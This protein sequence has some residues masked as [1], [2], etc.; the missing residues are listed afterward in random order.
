MEETLRGGFASGDANM[1]L[2]AHEPPDEHR[3]ATM[4]RKLKVLFQGSL[5][6]VVMFTCWSLVA[7][8][9]SAPKTGEWRYYNGDAAST[10]YSAL[11]QIDKTNV[12]DLSIVWRWKTENFGPR[13]AFAYEVTPLMIGGKLYVTAGTRRDV[14]AIDAVTGE[15]LWMWRY[16]EGKRG[17]EAPRSAH[18]GVAYWTDGTNDERIFYITAGYQ[19]VGLDAKTGRELKGFGKNGVVDLFDDLDSTMSKEGLIG[20]TSPPIV[21][22]NIVIVGGALESGLAPRSKEGVPGNIR[23]YD[24]RTGKRVWI[25]HT[26]PQPGEYGVDTWEK[27]SWRYTGG[28]SAWAP[29]TA[30]EELGYVYLPIGPRTG[31]YYGGH[32]PGSN[33]YD[34]SL[35]CLDAK[36]GKR[37]WHYQLVHHGLWDYDIAA[38]PIL[39]DITVNG[40]KIKAVA[41]LTKGPAYVF[42]FDR[43]TGKPVWPIEE[44]PVPQ[45]DVPGEKTWPTQPIPTKPAAYDRNGVS[46][47]DLIDFT[48]E[49]KAEAVKIVSDYKIGPLYTPPSL[50]SATGLRGTLG[51]PSTGSGAANWQGGAL[52]PE[53]GI[54]YIP[55]ASATSPLSLWHDP[56]TQHTNMDYIGLMGNVPPPPGVNPVDAVRQATQR[57]DQRGAEPAPAPAATTGANRPF[58]GPQGLPILKPPYG[59]ITAIDLNTGEQVWMVPNGETPD[60]IKNHPALRGLNIPKTGR[61]ERDGVLVTKTLLFAGDS[62]GTFRAYDK[63]TGEIVSEMKL[64]SGQTGVPM[65]YMV[66]GKQY[67]AVAIGGRASYAEIVVLALR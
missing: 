53:T 62:T 64:P 42:V 16:D 19:L 22:K 37:V 32:S 12:K 1:G 50:W 56:N 60:N 28:A 23:G 18:R 35:I 25:F 9:Q 3:R 21:V 43:V 44:R 8:G 54:L 31:D 41:Q 15:T 26:I 10:R 34:E 40:K 63:K 57:V 24:V 52:D 61:P 27:E 49:L 51:L 29:L 20:S 33:L 5:L 48:P 7:F 66:G 14:A 58:G 46:L 11:D 38:A 36:T 6:V 13:P 4:S 30:D 47:D 67:I 45:S 2:D 59:R 17:Q 55:S 39:L 65:S